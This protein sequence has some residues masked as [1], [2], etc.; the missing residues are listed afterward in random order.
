MIAT[1]NKAALAASQR[2]VG[3][4]W[5]VVWLWLAGVEGAVAQS[6]PR[7]TGF[8]PAGLLSWTNAPV[9]VEPTPRTTV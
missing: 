6:V 9:P 8:N 4:C 7:L 3:W 5:L 2:D 1:Q